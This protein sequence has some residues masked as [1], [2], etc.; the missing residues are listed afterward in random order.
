MADGER[1]M[2]RSDKRIRTRGEGGGL[3]STCAANY[4]HRGPGVDKQLWNGTGT[5][6]P[7]WI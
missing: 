1:R 5:S 7:G 2:E 4:G 3:T 6:E